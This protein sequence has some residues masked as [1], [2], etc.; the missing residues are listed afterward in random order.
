MFFSF[1]Y[2][3]ELRQDRR[4]FLTTTDQMAKGFWA[5]ETI[6][7]LTQVREFLDTKFINKKRPDRWPLGKQISYI[8]V[9]DTNQ[10]IDKSIKQDI[11]Y[12][13]LLN[14]ENNRLYNEKWVLVRQVSLQVPSG[15]QQAIFYKKLRYPFNTFFIDMSTFSLFALLF[16]IVFYSITYTFVGRTLKPVEENLNDMSDFIHNAGH[17]LKTPIS[18]IRWWLQVMQAEQ[19]LDK[20][21]VKQSI[22]E[23]DRL[24]ALIEWLIELAE[25]WKNTQKS[26]LALATEVDVI[27]KQFIDYAK[28]HGVK[29]KNNI[30]GQYIISANR[31]EFYVLFSN[32]LKNA[33]KYNTSHGEVI[34]D[35]TK[36]VLSI[37]DT[38]KW[39]SQQDL[40]NIFE[41]FYQGSSSRT[42]DGFWIGLSLVKKIAESNGWKIEVESKQGEGTVFFLTF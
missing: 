6:T 17:E 19:K 9:D 3:N 36:W 29:I 1:R 23:I 15:T 39:I 12:N 22:R 26:D 21:L 4:D 18:V 28:E 37:R 20:K 24:N 14:K 31:D 41:R 5:T 2:A 38:G 32:L 8:I 40:K 7:E 27:I 33:I 30:Q 13:I 11:D 25:T 35:Y 16:C 34:L 10:I 42:W